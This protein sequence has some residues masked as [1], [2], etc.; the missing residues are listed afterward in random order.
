[1]VNIIFKASNSNILIHV[2]L[3]LDRMLDKIIRHSITECIFVKSKSYSK[4]G[5]V[6]TNNPSPNPSP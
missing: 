2:G 6:K 4:K 3:L 1:M 5:N